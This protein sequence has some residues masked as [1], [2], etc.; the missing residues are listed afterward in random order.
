MAEK[1]AL[2]RIHR[3]GQTKPVVT[4]RYRTRPKKSVFSCYRD[5]IFFAETL[6]NIYEP[7]RKKLKLAALTISGEVKPDDHSHLE[8]RAIL[9]CYL[10]WA[11]FNIGLTLL[12][13]LKQL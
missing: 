13:Q 6:Q 9:L 3:M 11:Y 7:Q 12:A 4:V 8:V 2:S 10:R 1:Q 5:V